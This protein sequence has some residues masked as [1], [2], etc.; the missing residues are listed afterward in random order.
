MK[1]LESKGLESKASLS[2]SQFSDSM[3]VIA[4]IMSSWQYVKDVYSQVSAITYM[5]INVKLAF[6][7]FSNYYRRLN[8]SSECSAGRSPILRRAQHA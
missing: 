4:S 6:A 7:R 3:K 1:V 2:L 8:C 5:L